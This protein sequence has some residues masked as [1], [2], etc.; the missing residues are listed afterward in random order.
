MRDWHETVALIT[1][2][3]RGIGRAAALAMAARG[4]RV[5]ACARSEEALADLAG[6]GVQVRALDIRDEGAVAALFDAIKQADGRLDVLVNNASILGPT[7]PLEGLD[8]DAWRETIDVN[9]NG[10]FIVSKLATPLLRRG[11]EPVVIHLSSSVGRKG[12]AEWGAY[13]VS[14]FGVEAL[15]EIMAAEL[16]GDGVAVASLNPGGTATQMRAEAYPDEDPAT[17]P[18]AEQVAATILTLAETLTLEQSGQRFSS[19]EMF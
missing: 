6:V 4:A 3:S 11:H 12:R 16:A 2:A 8:V 13:S 17:L 15:N 10:T 19:R 18:T 5:W 1:G 9:V 7:G 14:K